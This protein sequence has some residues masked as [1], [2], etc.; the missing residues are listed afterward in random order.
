MVKLKI[1]KKRKKG[2]EQ[3]DYS[4]YAPSDA[5]WVMNANELVAGGGYV[6]VRLLLV[7]EEGVR[8]PDILDEFRA[9]AEYLDSFPLFESE[10]RIRPELPEVEIQ[11]EV[12]RCAQTAIWKRNGWALMRLFFFSSTSFFRLQRLLFATRLSFF[13]NFNNICLVCAWQAY[14]L[15]F[16][17]HG[18][19]I[20]L[21]HMKV[22]TKFS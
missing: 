8:Y 13:Q 16:L 10:P 22:Q 11:R 9:D 17:S 21:I 15:K 1:I 2:K 18:N 20:V 4:P 19:Y 5:T 3:K 14:F 7:D 6:K 12:L